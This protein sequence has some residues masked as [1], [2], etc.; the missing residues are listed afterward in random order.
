MSLARVKATG[1]GRLSA[2][3]VVEGLE[4]EAVTDHLRM[5]KTTADG[6]LR[7]GGL[8]L[9]DVVLGA[10]A[11]LMRAQVS[12]QSF[13]ARVMD[14]DRIAG[15]ERMGRVTQ[16]YMRRPGAQSMFLATDV[17]DADT[18]ITVRA[19]DPNAPAS[20]VIHIGTEAIAYD[21]ISGNDFIDCTRGY[22]DSIAQSHFAR[23]G[24]GLSD[25]RVTYW[26]QSIE[27]RRAYLYLYGEGDDPQG[28]GTLWWRGIV[29]TEASWSG[30]VVTFE[31]DSMTRLLSQPV[32]GD[33]AGSVGVRGVKYTDASPFVITVVH[34]PASS[35]EVQSIVTVRGFWETNDL[36][37]ADVTTALNDALTAAS[38]SL[39]TGASLTARARGETL[40]ISYIT[41]TS[42]PPIIAVYIND[43]YAHAV[44]RSS[45]TTTPTTSPVEWFDSS[46]LS[47]T[48]MGDR[49]WVPDVTSRYHFIIPAPTPRGTLGV[50]AAWDPYHRPPSAG[51]ETLEK[52][53]PLGGL[54]VLTE[55]S[56]V[57]PEGPEWGEDPRPIR[58][59]S[60]SGRDAYLLTDRNIVAYDRFTS[61]KIGRHLATGTVIDLVVEMILS[62]PDTANTGATP[63]IAAGDIQWTNEVDEA[64]AASRLA[65][66]RGFYVFDTGRTLGDFVTPELLALGCYAR[67]GAD[68]ALEWDRLRAPLS[69]DD[70]TWQIDESARA[71]ALAKAPEGT[72]GA[73]LYRTGYDPKEDEHSERTITYRDVQTSSA[74]RTPITLEIA[75]LSTVGGLSPGETWSVIDR[76]ELARV[77]MDAFGMFG[78]AVTVVAFETDARFMDARIGDAVSVTTRMLPDPVDGYSPLDGRAGMV[79]GHTF[80]PL[81]GRVGMTVMLSDSSFAGYNLGLPIEAQSDLGGDEWSLDVTLTGY[82]YDPDGSPTIAA[83][84]E[85]GTLVRITEADTATPTSEDGVVTAVTDSNTVVVQFASTWTPGASEWFLVARDSP[86]YE[87]AEGL[88]R[89]AFVGEDALEFDST[90][91]MLRVFA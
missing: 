49:E 15:S 87:S 18:T 5:R 33:L 3:L 48:R 88:G 63:L 25:A 47:V 41:A 77:A 17:D 32:G 19:M 36:F 28:D 62:S 34:Y 11:N 69:T 64:A 79:I 39:G 53:L 67:L 72:L 50:Y 70:V 13:T 9:R 42:S 8:D 84:L 73:V 52:L 16:Y 46:S 7:V 80:E 45:A 40:E 2:R 86:Y 65:G 71:W 38:I 6:R 29:A 81:T 89:Y 61:F 23:D 57:M 83:M 10:S 51:L 26:P 56:V 90:E 4:I 60:A 91:E 75:Q 74:T 58:V 55:S 31:V 1:R 59:Y 44:A 20:G 12:G 68:G 21:S 24:E 43:G 35:E 22:R 78:A 30:G 85:V 14:L 54:A 76:D 66:G 37:A 82:Y 27:G